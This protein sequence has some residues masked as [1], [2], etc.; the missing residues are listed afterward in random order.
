[1]TTFPNVE[2]VSR[3][4]SIDRRGDVSGITVVPDI[5]DVCGVTEVLVGC[6]V[7]DGCDVSDISFVPDIRGVTDISC[8]TDMENPYPSNWTKFL[9]LL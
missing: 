7:Y 4:L 1:M 3:S 8:V 5:C 9:G 2:T 6:Y